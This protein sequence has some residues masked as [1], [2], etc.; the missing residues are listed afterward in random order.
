M[1]VHSTHRPMS[2]PSTQLTVDQAGNWIARTN[3]TAT[4]LATELRRIAAQLDQQEQ[5]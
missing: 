2:D 3:Q 4:A 1:N 5:Q